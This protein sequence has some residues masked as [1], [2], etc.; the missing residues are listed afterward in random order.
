MQ[1]RRGAK[2]S[3]MKAV[4][5]SLDVTLPANAAP[6]AESKDEVDEGDDSSLYS[7]KDY[8]EPGHWTAIGMVRD[9][10]L[11]KDIQVVAMEYNEGPEP[12]GVDPDMPRSAEEDPFDYC[13]QPNREE[14]R[15][16]RLLKLTKLL[17]VVCPQLRKEKDPLPGRPRYVSWR[18]I[19]WA[20]EEYDVWKRH[21]AKPLTEMEKKQLQPQAVL[22]LA[23][24]Y[25]NS[26]D[27]LNDRIRVLRE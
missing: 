2:A 3:A 15:K 5:E 22:E 12:E 10:Y 11:N 20:G 25:G 19:P 7:E 21:P 14:D 17:E 24:K 18:D 27:V 4:T 8:F 6:I 1:T 23:T 16:E 26:A 9:S 13:L